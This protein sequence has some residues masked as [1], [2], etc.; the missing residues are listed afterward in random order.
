MVNQFEMGKVKGS[1]KA[2]VVSCPL[3]EWEARQQKERK[4]QDSLLDDTIDLNTYSG[5]DQPNG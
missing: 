3:K 4:H 1:Q 2:I 5:Q